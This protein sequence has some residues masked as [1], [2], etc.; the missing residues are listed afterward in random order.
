MI[1]F[2]QYIH[3]GVELEEAVLGICMLEKLAFGRTFGIIKPEMFYKA[4]HEVVYEAMTEMY[5]SSVPIDILTVSEWII[6]KKGV[7]NFNG[8]NVPYFVTRLTNTVVSSAHV[9]YH[10]HL[11]REMWQRREI[12]KIKFT[13]F[14]C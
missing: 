13:N 5:E 1:E 2:K 10:C 8:Y 12:L 14:A 11:I 4:S 6:S 9:E 7:E 3:H